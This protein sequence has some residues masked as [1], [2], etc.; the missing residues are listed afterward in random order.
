MLETTRAAEAP[1][2]FLRGIIAP[3]YTPVHGDGSLDEEGAA[4]MVRW[5]AACGCVRTL[6]ARSGMGRMFSFTMEET[7]RFAAAVKAALPPG[8][9]LLVGAGGEWLEHERGGRPDA[10][11]YTE[12]AIELTRWAA[13][14]GADGAVHV[15]PYGL[16]PRPG[17]TARD[18][19]LRHYREVHDATDLPLVLYQPGGVPEEY[20]VTPGL[21]EKLLAMPRI[22]GM[23]VSTEEDAVF[24]PLA[25]VVRGT[26]FALICGHEGYYARGLPQ[27]GV[28]VIG[29]GCNGY[30]EVLDGVQRRFH[31]G[32]R[33]G[34]ARAQ[35]DV[36][37]GLDATSGLHSAVALKQYIARKGYRVGPA[38]R[39]GGE[40]YPPEVIDRLE[41]ALDTLRA[42]YRAG[43]A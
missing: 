13:G 20:R 32:D 10:R 6:F 5:L 36:Q 23:K 35:E 21:L 9:G 42:Q 24:T 28:G 15:I 38:D 39:G 30:P 26:R 18:T 4:E 1:P 2:D 14:A 40:P 8:M 11:R 29:Q 43:S 41:R 17:E 27:G 16:E 31:A 34:S 3:M 12:Q 25:E 22:A 19:V 7:L 37:R 33:A